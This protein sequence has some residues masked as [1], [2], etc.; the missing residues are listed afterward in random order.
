[1]PKI[2]RTHRC[3]AGTA[4]SA[5]CQKCGDY[6]PAI[7][8]YED[9]AKLYRRGNNSTFNNR[10]LSDNSK[11]TPFARTAARTSKPKKSVDHQSSQQSITS[12]KPIAAPEAPQEA[13]CDEP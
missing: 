7:Q 11:C 8:K 12:V 10:N 13:D 6:S 5:T 9:A 3:E 2:P 1:M 4:V